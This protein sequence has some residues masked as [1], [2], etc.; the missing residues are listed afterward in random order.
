MAMSGNKW[1]RRYFLKSSTVAAGG[2]LMGDAF[3]LFARRTSNGTP[4]RAVRLR[5]AE[6]SASTSGRIDRLIAAFR[7]DGFAVDRESDVFVLA[8]VVK[9]RVGIR[10]HSIDATNYQTGER[11]KVYY[12]EG[13]PYEMGLL[14][15]WMAA[16]AVYLMTSQ[17]VDR[18]VLSFVRMQSPKAAG[19]KI[20]EIIL[21]SIFEK[22]DRNVGSD[23]PA[24][25]N[26]ELDGIVDGCRTADRPIRVK[27]KHLWLLSTGIDAILAHAY[28]GSLFKDRQ[29][30][31]QDLNIP[32]ACN[33]FSVSGR[34]A[35][36]GH[37]F[38]RDFMYKDVQ[39]FQ[40]TAC[41]MIYRPDAPGDR[42]TLVV[43]QTAP[44]M[45]G[46]I[47]AMNLDGVAMG[48]DMLPLGA[49]DP[50]RPGFNSLLLV[51][52]CIQ[53]AASATEVADRITTAK[54]G[55]SWLYPVADAGGRAGVIETGMSV[56]LN[57]E[58]WIRYALSFPAKNYIPS[59][60]DADFLRR[61]FR[62]RSE[63][64]RMRLRRGVAVRWSDSEYPRGYIDRFNDGLWRRFNREG[65]PDRRAQLYPDA[66]AD[67]GAINRNPLEKNCPDVFYFAPPRNADPEVVLT[68]NHALVPEMRLF[69]MTSWLARVTR[70]QVNDIQWRYDVLSREIQ[71]A[72]NAGPI[73]EERARQIVDFLA[74]YGACPDYYR[75]KG[76]RSRDGRELAINGSVSLF[77]L[78]NR[79][80]RSHYG[81]YCD[82]WVKITLP[83][84]K[85]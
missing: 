34:A 63:E 30:L 80:V 74:P 2:A 56:D 54:R 62:A 43:S 77:D 3:G 75:E 15:G 28:T 53:N 49:C 18:L 17:Y 67:D 82:G 58:E 72:L 57:E 51:R 35:G 11:K 79:V 14:T 25:L 85:V 48:V 59:L 55:V 27:K 84:Y 31:P 64:D 19:N 12:V 39:V 21:E 38:G 68:T 44:G 26:E 60:P 1:D 8:G 5:P 73:L 10:G 50:K 32:V 81:Y 45:A 78:K 23:V 9:E 22:W 24:S 40:D 6:V 16:E 37:Y 7:S 36:G 20:V 52:H 41:V 66:F 76:Q 83:A 70:S 33:A 4:V 65:Y 13:T 69:G 61:Q 42:D 71:K 46:S 47:A 29:I